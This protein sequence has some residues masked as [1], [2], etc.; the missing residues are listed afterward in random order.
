ML[1]DPNLEPGNLATMVKVGV[2]KK[3]YNCPP[4]P[5]IKG[6]YYEMFRGLTQAMEA[7]SS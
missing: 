2:N 1:S 7:A 5:A 4:L 6:K 3:A